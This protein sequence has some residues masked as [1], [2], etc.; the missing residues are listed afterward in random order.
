MLIFANLKQLCHDANAR[1]RPGD[2]VGMDS[3]VHGPLHDQGVG[4]GDG[5]LDL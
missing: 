1:V 5:H 2:R 3:R 4:K